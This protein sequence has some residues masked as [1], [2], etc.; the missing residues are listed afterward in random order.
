MSWKEQKTQRPTKLSRELVRVTQL[1]NCSAP[2]YNCFS[3]PLDRVI[4]TNSCYLF[5]L[6][7]LSC[8]C[9]GCRFYT[10]SVAAYASLSRS[11]H[12]RRSS[13]TRAIQSRIASSYLPVCHTSRLGL[14]HPRTL[15]LKLRTLIRF[16]TVRNRLLYQAFFVIR[17]PSC[18][19]TG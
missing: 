9:S 16:A 12:A 11:R 10:N 6:Y 2:T 1:K 14:L 13:E 8:V 5:H 17:V 7:L 18:L 15:H 3:L 4:L 19:H